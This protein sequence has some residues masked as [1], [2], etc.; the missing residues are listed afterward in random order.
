MEIYSFLKR[1]NFSFGIVLGLL[2]CMNF[3]L[4]FA[5]LLWI[6]QQL[7]HVVQDVK[8]MDML[9]LSFAIN[10]IVMRYYFVKLKF[11]HTGKGIMIIT[12]AFVII[13]FIFLKG[14]NFTILK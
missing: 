13:Y 5:G 10:L 9:L 12:L 11:E 8:Q 7:L 4:I 3:S 2:I 14:S 1:D 6:A